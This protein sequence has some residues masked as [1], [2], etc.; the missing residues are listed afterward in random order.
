MGFGGVEKEYLKTQDFPL[1]E[2]YWLAFLFEKLRKRKR[3][4]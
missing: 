1:S 2:K 4:L 3:G